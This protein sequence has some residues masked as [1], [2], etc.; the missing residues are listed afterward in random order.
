MQGSPV[1]EP[2]PLARRVANTEY[3]QQA[4]VAVYK[5]GWG[6]ELNA[7]FYRLLVGILLLLVTSAVLLSFV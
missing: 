2:Q 4:Q 1:R 5:S 3:T 7:L 6:V